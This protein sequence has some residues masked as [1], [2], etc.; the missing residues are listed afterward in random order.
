[1]KVGFI[2]DE[3]LAVQKEFLQHLL[4]SLILFCFVFLQFTLHAVIC[5][6]LNLD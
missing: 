3:C 4:L 5:C 6:F 2:C 1:M